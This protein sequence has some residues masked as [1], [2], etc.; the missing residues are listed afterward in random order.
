MK[1]VELQEAQEQLAGLIEQAA[2]C[3][4]FIIAKDG[5]PLVTVTAVE[6]GPTFEQLVAQ[7]TPENRYDECHF[8]F[9]EMRDIEKNPYTP[10][11][12]RVA[13]FLWEMTNGAVGAGDDPIGF[14]LS[15]Y[16]YLTTT[17]KQS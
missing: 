4:P 13:K 17:G 1:T 16:A 10:D 12:A 11:E 3:G 6:Q 8:A 5:K 15:S 7:I 2:Q 9:T 14:L